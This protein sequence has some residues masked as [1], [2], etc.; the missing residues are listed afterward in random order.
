MNKICP[1]MG[2]GEKFPHPAHC[3]SLERKRGPKLYNMWYV[4]S[5][6]VRNISDF[7]VDFIYVPGP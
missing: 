2:S 7:F 5:G 6:K 3:P 4:T 1:S